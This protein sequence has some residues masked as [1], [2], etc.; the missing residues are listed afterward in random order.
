[1]GRADADAGAGGGG[2]GASLPIGILLA[3]GRRSKMPVVKAF[4]VTCSSSSG[5]ACR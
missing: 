1:M 4:C 2:H 5:A 3:L